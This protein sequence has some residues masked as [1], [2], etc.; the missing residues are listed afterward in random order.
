MIEHPVTDNVKWEWEQ[1]TYK[2]VSSQCKSIA[3]SLV[4]KDT[5]MYTHVQSINVLVWH[6]GEMKT[7]PNQETE[8]C[9]DDTLQPESSIAI[10]RFSYRD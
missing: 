7:V 2:P 9:V 10:K 3:P 6:F 8:L 4:N 1:I 5:Y